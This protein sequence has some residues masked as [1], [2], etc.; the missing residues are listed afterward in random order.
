MPKNADSCIYKLRN[1]GQSTIDIAN[2]PAYD[3]WTFSQKILHALDHELKARRQRR[4]QKLLKAPRTSNPQACIKE[5]RYL[6]DRSLNREVIG[7]LASCRWIDQTR[8]LVV[9]GTSS[10][11]KTYLAQALLNAACR[12]FYT[13]RYFRLDVLANQL[14]VMD[15]NSQHRLDFLAEP[16]HN[17][18]VLVFDE[19]C[20]AS[21]NASTNLVGSDELRQRSG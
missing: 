17:C 10:V 5:L 18:D 14:A 8:N 16:L 7:R 15:H 4:S 11:S 19:L 21:H 12:K 3:D 13:A 2:D 6:P 1:S 20:E 9:L